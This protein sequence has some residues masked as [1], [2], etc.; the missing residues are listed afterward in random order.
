MASFTIPVFFTREARSDRCFCLQVASARKDP[1]QLNKFAFDTWTSLSSTRLFLG[2]TQKQHDHWHIAKD[3]IRQRCQAMRSQRFP[4]FPSLPL[5]IQDQIWEACI[6]PVTHTVLCLVEVDPD[7]KIL[8]KTWL[9]ESPSK[10][11]DRRTLPVPLLHIC[12]RSRAVGRNFYRL[13]KTGVYYSPRFDTLRLSIISATKITRRPTASPDPPRWRYKATSSVVGGPFFH[14]ESFFESMQMQVNE[15]AAVYAYHPFKS[16]WTSSYK[17]HLHDYGPPYILTSLPPSLLKQVQNLEV[18]FYYEPYASVSDQEELSHVAT[19]LLNRHCPLLD[20][21]GLR[22]LSLKI[23]VVTFGRHRLPDK[24]EG[25]ESWSR[26]MYNIAM[27]RA[28]RRDHSRQGLPCLQ[29]ISVSKVCAVARGGFHFNQDS[30][31]LSARLSHTRRRF[32]TRLS[33]KNWQ[34]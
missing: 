3:V 6:E 27:L 13:V 29:S 15:E 10:K 32:L 25:M 20:L 12:R 30:S 9:F 28:A 21:T 23:A 31:A 17:S 24:V 33:G 26:L 34:P 4:L 8:S 18:I 19:Y 1:N 5:E 2:N 16:D 22:Y 11:A 14:G 7:D